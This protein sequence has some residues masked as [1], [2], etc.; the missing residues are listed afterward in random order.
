MFFSCFISGKSASCLRGVGGWRVWDK[1]P[2]ALFSSRFGLSPSSDFPSAATSL[3]AL[4]DCLLALK[5][6]GGIGLV[7][8]G[9]PPQG[10]CKVPA[11]KTSHCSSLPFWC[12]LSMWA[13]PLHFPSLAYPLAEQYP[14]DIFYFSFITA[15]LCQASG[16][17][18]NRNGWGWQI[19]RL[20]YFF[21]Y[22]IPL[23][24]LCRNSIRA[25]A[26]NSDV[27]KQMFNRS[28]VEQS[29]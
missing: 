10:L 1:A 23:R 12:L 28:A 2:V 4:P 9:C 26:Y 16:K 13:F 14:L 20:T 24:I 22:K 21:G 8:Q 27:T 29:I 11:H 6:N 5:E 18:S 25:E 19:W 3:F 7:N 17:N 15:F